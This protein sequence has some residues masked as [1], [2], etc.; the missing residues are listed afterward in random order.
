MVICSALTFFPA[1]ILKFQYRF[2]FAVFLILSTLTCSNED[3][4]Q[5]PPPVTVPKCEC[6][7]KPPITDGG[8]STLDST[9]TNFSVR[10]G[11]EVNIPN[12]KK[13]I[14]ANIK[15]EGSF[16]STNVD[17]ENAYWE[18]REG[19]PTIAQ[20]SYLFWTVACALYEITCAD[21]TINDQQREMEKRQIV[22][23][24]NTKLEKF[25]YQENPADKETETTD[26]NRPIQ[27]FP[28]DEDIP[29][30]QPNSEPKY[31]QVKLIVDA[32]FSNAGFFINGAAINPLPQSTLTIK[33]FEIEFHESREFIL[34]AKSGNQECRKPFTIPS[35]YFE[36]PDTITLICSR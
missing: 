35:N 28:G 3:A 25:V 15:A 23:D 27:P 19:D 6:G 29:L 8:G 18:I 31:I 5:E 7:I 26:L 2:L 36:N 32:I 12:I 22:K 14:D 17:L 34:S 30:K 1:S 13:L 33:E 20:S 24:Y 9:N 21:T 4:N 16:K 11:V 10:G